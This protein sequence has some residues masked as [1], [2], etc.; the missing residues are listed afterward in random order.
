MVSV[1]GFKVVC[2]LDMVGLF[3]YL[4]LTLRL[5][6]AVVLFCCLLVISGLIV[7]VCLSVCVVGLLV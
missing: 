3:F 4:W 5:E 6:G 2:F 1:C 7:M